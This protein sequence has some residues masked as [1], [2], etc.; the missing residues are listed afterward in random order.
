MEKRKVSEISGLLSIIEDLMKSGNL[1]DKSFGRCAQTD[2]L[3]M[4]LSSHILGMF[5]IL[6]LDLA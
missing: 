2:P 3:W 4:I 6:T 1:D 5:E